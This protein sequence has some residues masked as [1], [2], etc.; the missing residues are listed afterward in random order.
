MNCL[1]WLSLHYSYINFL[2]GFCLYEII[3]FKFE[4]KK[5]AYLLE[6]G[7]DLKTFFFFLTFK[8]WFEI[9]LVILLRIHITPSDHSI[10]II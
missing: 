5:V 4:T 9:N 6:L 10:F 8:R 7:K 2:G 1:Y 3:F